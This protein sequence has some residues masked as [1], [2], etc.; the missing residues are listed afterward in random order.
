MKKYWLKSC[1][2]A[3]FA[4]VLLG[5]PLRSAQAQHA[6][7][8][9]CPPEQ[10]TWGWS[11][12]WTYPTPFPTPTPHLFCGDGVCSAESGETAATCP[13]DC[14]FCGDNVCS[15]GENS[16][17][18]AEDCAFCGDNICSP[19]IESNAN[20][21]QDCV[22][23]G[24][25][26]CGPGENTSNC[27]QDCANCGDGICSANENIQN[28]ARDCSVCGDGI[29]SDGENCPQDCNKCG[30]GV[31]DQ[32]EN[33]NNC[34]QDCKVC[35]DG[36]CSA[37]ETKKNC[38][39]DCGPP[40]V[41]TPKPTPTP[42]LLNCPPGVEFNCN[43][44]LQICACGRCAHDPFHKECLGC[45]SPETKIMMAD[46]TMRTI[47]QIKAGDLVWNPVTE[48]AI[49]VR[50]MTM[51]PEEIP[52]YQLGYG[53]TSIEVTE[54]HPVIVKNDRL[55]ADWIAL[56]GVVGDVS[57]RSDKPQLHSEMPR[58]YLVKK[59]SELTIGDKVFGADGSFHKLTVLRKLP[60]KPDQVV[61]N[62][63]LDTDSENPDDR[64]LVADG[65]VTGDLW[66]QLKLDG[67]NEGR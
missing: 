5:A 9:S 21:P 60:V 57:L 4:I 41:P 48:K 35:G 40:P 33:L 8:D 55:E 50:Y 18:C 11:Q 51:G 15:F 46:K 19:P 47:S 1:L 10:C 16:E 24:D 61:L 62:I 3:A 27:A 26:I 39:D 25:G 28:C 7:E 67:K 63:R 31:C 29:C 14:G 53:T 43:A 20:C 34:A 52:M 58:G 30:N 66:L 49:A 22:V 59:A 56:S 38:P 17:N 23:C 54:G 2:A 65:I 36:I 37:G 45:F 12:V 64:M 13:V 44:A 32:G 6:G 42:P